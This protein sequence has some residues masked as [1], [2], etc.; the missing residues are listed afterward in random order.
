MFLF[1]TTI[2][3]YETAFN[4]IHIDDNYNICDR[5]WHKCSIMVLRWTPKT[6]PR[7]VSDVNYTS[8]SWSDDAESYCW[9]TAPVPPG[10]ITVAGQTAGSDG[11]VY[12]V[13]PDN[14]TM[15]ITPHAPP[16]RYSY[17]VGAS[18]YT[19]Q[20]QANNITLDPVQTNATLCV[21]Q[22]V[23]FTL[24]GSPPCVLTLVHWNLP[25]KFVNSINYPN[26]SGSA[27]YFK[28]DSLLYNIS[29]PDNIGTSCW[30]VNGTGGAVSATVTFS[31]AN[32]QTATLAAIGKFA[33]YRPTVTKPIMWTQTPYQGT[34]HQGTIS[35]LSLDNNDMNFEL[36]ISSPYGGIGNFVQLVQADCTS[37]VLPYYQVTGSYWLDNSYPY[38]SNNIPI[39]A[40]GNNVWFVDYPSFPGNRLIQIN[41]HYETYL[42]YLPDPQGSSIW[43]TLQ[44]ITWAWAASAQLPINTLT[45]DINNPPALITSGPSDSD[46]FPVWQSTLKNGWP[47]VPSP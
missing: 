16:Q 39:F 2:S 24:T 11:N 5:S 36:S 21:G 4:T 37:D 13:L 26:P 12:T 38:N 14:L 30:Y 40:N 35:T 27:N 44:K 6:R 45:W 47:A 3:I 25:D 42:V 10:Q 33:I 23:N 34:F 1:F 19:P 46:E 8:T 18:E 41:N 29:P 31:F 32:G 43:V 7:S 15:D 9:N 20:I 28:D 22:Q 17:S